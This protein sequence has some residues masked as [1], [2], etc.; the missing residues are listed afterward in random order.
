[1]PQRINKSR[2]RERERESSLSLSISI[3]ISISLSSKRHHLSIRQSMAYSAAGQI[4]AN[5]AKGGR[6][7]IPTFCQDKRPLLDP[8]IPAP[9]TQQSQSFIS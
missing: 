3:S 6:T 7:H 4:M 5:R 2:E 1:M 8:E 9:N